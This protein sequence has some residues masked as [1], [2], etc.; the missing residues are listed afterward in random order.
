[1]KR[2][3]TT[4]V[5]I[6]SGLPAC[7]LEWSKRCADC[8]DFPDFPDPSASPDAA[9]PDAEST[10]LA[11]DPLAD[12][13]F[14][15]AG[16][17][18]AKTGSACGSDPLVG[19]YGTLGHAGSFAC[20]TATAASPG[21]T[22][23]AVLPASATAITS[24][25]PGYARSDYDDGNGVVSVE[26]L[27]Y[28]TPAEAYAGNPG[29][30]APN[31]A[32]P[33]ACNATDALGEFG[34]IPDGSPTSNGEHCMYS[35]SFEIDSSNVWHPSAASDAVGLCID[36]TRYFYSPSGG[37]W[38]TVLPPCASLPV[39]GV[40]PALGAVDIGC[41]SSTTAGLHGAFDGKDPAR[42]IA[43]RR[44]RLGIALPELR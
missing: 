2:A 22:H 17:A 4:L 16:S 9:S 42:A 23:R 32:A 36:H 40:Q 3:V 19:C 18:H 5:C 20:M 6:A 38:T 28:C 30:Q 13:D 21:L 41:V 43:E 11:C 27:A 1:M 39:H 44:L 37:P 25:M 29:A 31:G 8:T 7:H 26:C 14:D 24:C 33:H 12:N 10:A 35:W 15:G 34:A